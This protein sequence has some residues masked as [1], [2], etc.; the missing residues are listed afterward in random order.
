M[1]QAEQKNA[2]KQE[3]FARHKSSY[4]GGS[5]MIYQT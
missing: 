4:S 3:L 5:E 2:D 1:S